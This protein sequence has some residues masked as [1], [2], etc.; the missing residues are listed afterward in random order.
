[1]IEI[2]PLTDSDDLQLVSNIYE[3]SWKYA[4]RGII[5]DTYLDSI[6]NGAWA[7][8]LQAPGRHSLLLLDN[9]KP[10]GTAS[11]APA[12]AEEMHGYGE[13]ISI[14]LL[15]EA[16]HMGYGKLL[17]NAAVC[18]LEKSGFKNVYLWVLEKNFSARR[19]Y[20]HFGFKPNGK[21]QTDVIG[22]KEVKEMLYCFTI[23]NPF[24]EA[25]CDAAENN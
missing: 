10:I 13:I 5:P 1:M 18:A 7:N 17:L 19:F 15:P 23:N 9:A 4:Y 22:G 2:K 3:Q 25:Y 24:P 12:R 14:Y 8:G 6:P 20:E 11:Y 16:M 21:V